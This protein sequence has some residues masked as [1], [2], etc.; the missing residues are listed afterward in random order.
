MFSEQTEQN[1]RKLAQ[2]IVNNKGKEER[3]F[4]FKR[5]VIPNDIGYDY[6]EGNSLIISGEEYLQYI[7]CLESL[8]NEREL[9]YLSKR[10]IEKEL[11]HLVCEIFFSEEQLQKAG[12]LRKILVSF[13]KRL[14]KP[15]EDY[16]IIIPIENLKFGEYVHE[17]GGVKFLEMSPEFAQKWGIIKESK[18]H[19]L[20]YKVAI[21][22]V[23]AILS[24][25]GAD[26]S[27]AA[28]RARE[29]VNTA[30]NMLRFALLLDHEP[31][32]IGWKIH[33]EEMLFK[34]SEYLAVRKSGDSSV[35]NFEWHRRFRSIEFKME[36]IISKQVKASREMIEYLFG[37]SGLRGRMRDRILRALEWISNSVVR[38]ELDDK[39]VDVCTALETLLTTKDDLR[40]GEC[41][42]LR[43]TILYTKLGKSFF[44]PVHVMNL[45]LKRSDIVHGSGRRVCTE[46][47]YWI[48]RWIASDV[49]S[50]SLAYIQSKGITQHSAFIK[51]LQE[52]RDMVQKAVDF[53]KEYPEYH[54]DILAAAKR[55]IG[56]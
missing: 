27:K 37:N 42:A 31:R 28:Q 7:N 1:L 6:S 2:S 22:K 3:P 56:N 40:K 36:E 8:T 17:I 44:D 35:I 55:I 11:W 14:R 52:D 30:L 34:Q 32:I 51:S 48:G 24:E 38:E 20:F 25:Q 23:I 41:I 45:Y 46:S 39:V 49:L 26:S 18:F 53:W 5:G 47:D 50:K 54:H 12:G 13:Q 4:P 43:M 16:E 21:N 33:D 15:L 29:K 10:G 9:E 19:E